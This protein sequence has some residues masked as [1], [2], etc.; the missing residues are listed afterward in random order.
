VLYGF[1]A[2]RRYGI[3]GRHDVCPLP[4]PEWRDRFLDEPVGS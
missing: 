4:R 3:F 2:A 1:V